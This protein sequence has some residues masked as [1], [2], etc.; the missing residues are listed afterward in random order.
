MHLRQMTSVLS[1]A[2]ESQTRS[3]DVFVTR[4]S[5]MPFVVI[6]PIIIFIGQL[7]LAPA[8]NGHV[9]DCRPL[10]LDKPALLVLRA[11][12]FAIEDETRRAQFVEE[13]I[14][15]I[16]NPD[17]VLRDQIA[18][19]AYATLL[20]GKHIPP[21]V[22]QRLR[23][24]LTTELATSEPDVAGFQRPFAALLLS[25]VARTD[26]IEPIFTD[27][28]R[29]NLVETAV[30]YLRSIEDYRGY[31]EA[32]GWRHGVAHAADLLLQL[33]LN[34]TLNGEQLI[35]IRDAV[36]SQVK[37]SRSHFYIYGENDRLA[38]PIIA[39]A[40]R[41]VLD[42]GSWS[43]WFESLASPAPFEA[44]GDVYSTQAGLSMLHNTRAFA[45]SVYVSASA[46]GSDAYK[47]L[48]D[49]A[50]AILRVLP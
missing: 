37:P 32:E 22:I 18:Y 4:R 40:N 49:G 3:R 20:R 24:R 23:R 25:E 50:L 1:G 29:Q 30:S 45:T 42:S 9:A 39:I 6:A 17:P 44:W 21:D 34:H 5:A 47:P 13:L 36:A 27:E 2:T 35:A 48:I 12:G 14:G 10:G 16:G 41:G 28:E 31:S 19:E 46:S 7:V 38:R 26:R 15:C 8:A 33:A 11:D 43:S